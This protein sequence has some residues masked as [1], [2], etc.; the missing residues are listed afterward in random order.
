MAIKYCTDGS[1]DGTQLMVVAFDSF[2][3]TLAFEIC[4]LKPL[5]FIS[6]VTFDGF[7]SALAFHWRNIKNF[8]QQP[9]WSATKLSNTA[10]I[11]S[12]VSF[13]E[14]FLSVHPGSGR[15][16]PPA[17]HYDGIDNALISNIRNFP[18]QAAV[19]HLSLSFPNTTSLI[20]LAAQYRH[21]SAKWWNDGFFAIENHCGGFNGY[22]RWKVNFFFNTNSS[23]FQTNYPNTS[24]LGMFVAYAPAF[25]ICILVLFNKLGL[26]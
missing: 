26:L 21:H 1:R 22:L 8:M 10:S 12:T 20:H 24:K 4:Q 5:F 14:Y 13:W 2:S 11:G 19:L 17:R 9:A 16:P 15:H 3:P 25:L 7:S 6:I 23:S 18:I